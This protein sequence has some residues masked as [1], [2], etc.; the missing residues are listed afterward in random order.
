[1]GSGVEPYVTQGIAFFLVEHRARLAE[2]CL[3]ARRG[4]G[5]RSNEISADCLVQKIP[6]L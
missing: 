3:V 2:Q 6:L 5:Y 4:N 1:M